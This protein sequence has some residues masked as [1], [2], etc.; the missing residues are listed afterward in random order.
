[1]KVS[2]SINRASLFISVLLVLSFTNINIAKAQ[3]EDSG[4]ILRSGTNDANLL[5]EEYM[6]PFAKGFGAGLNSGWVNVLGPGLTP[7][8]S[9]LL[10]PTLH[11]DL[12][13]KSAYHLPVFPQVTAV[14]LL[15]I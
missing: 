6:K 11:L 5:M 9:I 8:G 4:E 3:F 10:P 13:L 15:M 1:M 14:L 2:S 12:M 7:A